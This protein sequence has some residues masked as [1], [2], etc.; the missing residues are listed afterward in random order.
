[1]DNT[2][3]QTSTPLAQAFFSFENMRSI[4]DNLRETI[5]SETGHAIDYQNYDDMAAIM[6]YIYITN[7]MNP[8]SDVE[9][10]LGL[11]NQR[12][13]DNL[14]K[15]IK[16]GLAQRLAYLRNLTSSYV[17]QDNPVNTSSYGNKIG[18]NDKIGL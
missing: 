7:S 13:F 16:T 3:R 2:L 6:R 1:M 18:Y 15:Q 4:Q 11:L 9:N 17:P 10:Q 8:Y 5:R 14:L 12:S